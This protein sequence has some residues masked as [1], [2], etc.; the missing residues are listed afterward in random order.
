MQIR[1]CTEASR[2]PL[3]HPCPQRFSRP[4]N[5]TQTTALAVWGAVLGTLSFAWN[6]WTW[7]R[8]RPRIAV[9]VELRE[10]LDESAIC[11]EIRNRG[12]KP[13]T[14]EE[15]MLVKYQ[16]G[17]PG[18]LHNFEHVENVSAKHR[19]TAKL[20]V[21]LSPGDIWKG[22]SSINEE[23][24][25]MEMDKLALIAEGRLY[26]K[27]RCAHTGRLLSGKVKPEHPKVRL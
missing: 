16:D 11:Y 15:I 20:P 18:L 14:V 10:M 8:S 21:Q 6:V 13:T 12:D 27:V 2:C 5:S 7:L 22:H 1:I 3:P 19:E 9:K 24:G 23:R 17:L 25:L 26:F 4:M